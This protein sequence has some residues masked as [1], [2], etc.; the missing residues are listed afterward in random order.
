M[1]LVLLFMAS[2]NW[3]GAGI[4]MILLGFSI[5]FLDHFSEERAETYHTKIIESM[6]RL[7]HR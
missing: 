3:K 5:I 2:P 7:E 4:G 6:S 1:S